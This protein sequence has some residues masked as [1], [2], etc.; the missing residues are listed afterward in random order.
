MRI[1]EQLLRQKAEHNEGRL[2]DLEELALHQ[3]EIERIEHFDMLCRHIKILLLQNNMIPKMENLSKLKE[4]E[5]IN[6]TLNNIEK[7][8]GLEG[9]D[10]LKKIDLTC[11]FIGAENLLESVKNLRKCSSI[12]EVYLMGNPLCDFDKYKQIVIAICPNIQ[13]IDGEKITPSQRIISS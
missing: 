3:L 5:Y 7:I 8:E 11:N 6:L 12:E 10:S 4:L 1:T 2:I 13:S 9:C